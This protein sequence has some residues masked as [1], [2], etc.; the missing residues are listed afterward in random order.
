MCGRISTSATNA[1]IRATTASK[2]PEARAL[3]SDEAALSGGPSVITIPQALAEFGKR[4]VL[5]LR[6]AALVYSEFACNFAIA[7]VEIEEERNDLLLSR[8]KALPGALKVHPVREGVRGATRAPGLKRR[9]LV[10]AD[11]RR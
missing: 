2:Y 1:R 7:P 3:A 5:D 4:C 8:R 6:D 11:R 10:K 9:K